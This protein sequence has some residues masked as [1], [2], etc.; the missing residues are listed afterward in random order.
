MIPVQYWPASLDERGQINPGSKTR[1]STNRNHFI[2]RNPAEL[3]KK[4]DIGPA[5]VLHIGEKAKFEPFAA[6]DYLGRP[7]EL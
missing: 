5:V 7:K 3:K 4:L 1:D 2:K 6:Y